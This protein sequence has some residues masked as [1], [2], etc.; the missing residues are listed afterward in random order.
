M[1]MEEGY[2]V[3]TRRNHLKVHLFDHGSVAFMF[4]L[5]NDPGEHSP[6]DSVDPDLMEEA[7]YYLATPPLFNPTRVMVENV[8]LDA[9][10]NLGYI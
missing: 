9:L 4:E 10:E 8:F 3:T 7:R 6:L 2:V 1:N 5:Q